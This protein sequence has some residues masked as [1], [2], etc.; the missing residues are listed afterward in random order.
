LLFELFDYINVKNKKGIT[1]M[2]KSLIKQII[3]EAQ[4]HQVLYEK[5]L[6]TGDITAEERDRLQKFA[7]EL[8]YS[9]KPELTDNLNDI[10]ETV[11]LYQINYAENIDQLTKVGDRISIIHKNIPDY[12]HDTLVMAYARRNNEFQGVVSPTPSDET[13]SPS[14]VNTPPPDATIKLIET[15]S[16]NISNIL[17]DTSLSEIN[18]IKDILRNI[19]ELRRDIA[20][21]KQ[22]YKDHEHIAEIVEY[23]KTALNNILAFTKIVLDINILASNYINIVDLATIWHKHHKSLDVFKREFPLDSIGYTDK[24]TAALETFEILLKGSQYYNAIQIKEFCDTISTC[25]TR[26]NFADIRNIAQKVQTALARGTNQLLLVQNAFAMMSLTLEK[27]NI[28]TAT[29]QVKSDKILNLLNNYVL[30]ARSTAKNEPLQQQLHLDA[31]WQDILKFSLES[32]GFN[33]EQNK[34]LSPN[35]PKE[36]DE[37]F[38]FISSRIAI[39][40]IVNAKENFLILPKNNTAPEHY[41]TESLQSSGTETADLFT[42]AFNRARS[43]SIT[44]APQYKQLKDDIRFDRLKLR[45]HLDSLT[46]IEKICDDASLKDVLAMKLTM[47]K[48]Y[49]SLLS[50][51]EL[52]DYFTKVVEQTIGITDVPMVINYNQDLLKVLENEFEERRKPG[53]EI[54]SLKPSKP[55]NEHVDPHNIDHPKIRG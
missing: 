51:K 28:V 33:Y 18:K 43:K 11:Y 34:H 36:L 52:N 50:H 15:Y 13:L 17:A 38:K 6:L 44:R 48:A 5:L 49:C 19:T 31:I 35:M 24:E 55:E 39:A 14:V 30:V 54:S 42:A 2:P 29:P 21:A 12:M 9:N 1:N 20:E 3:E 10:F 47:Q 46:S 23:Y 45:M 4:L 37:G 7:T 27:A 22:K 25:R 53:D 26:G 40:A 16:T 32:L 8:S 41:V